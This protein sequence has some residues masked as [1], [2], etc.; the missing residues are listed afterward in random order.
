MP[1][2]V[3]PGP[4]NGCS[5]NGR[6][7]SRDP[8]SSGSRACAWIVDDTGIPKKGRHSVGVARQYC[9][10]LGKQDNCQVAVSLS[11]ATAAAQERG[12][13]GGAAAPGSDV[14]RAPVAAAF[15][16]PVAVGWGCAAAVPRRRR[17]ARL[18][19]FQ[20][21]LVFLRDGLT[22]DSPRRTSGADLQ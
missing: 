16:R 12:A 14:G 4:S 9:G 18:A 2:A 20:R 21:A 3:S 10:Q 8:S 15:R 5:S 19:R 7:T 6:K 13:D 11:V 1:G 17:G 22:A